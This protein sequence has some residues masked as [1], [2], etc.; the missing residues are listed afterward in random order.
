MNRKNYTTLGQW[1]AKYYGDY[2]KKAAIFIVL[3]LCFAGIA[4]AQNC[5]YTED[6]DVYENKGKIFLASTK[7]PVNGVVCSYHSNGK[8]RDE[9]PFKNGLQEGITK[10]YYESGKLE[11]EDPYKNDKREGIAK[12]YYE[13]GK[14]KYETL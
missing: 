14:L 6:K 7:Q 5:Q 2:M 13:S 4:N 3:C 1:I 9:T 12:S 11:Y 8:I 10:C